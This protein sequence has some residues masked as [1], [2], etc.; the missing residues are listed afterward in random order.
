MW[1]E[2]LGSP[3]LRGRCEEIGE[4]REGGRHAGPEIRLQLI[5]AEAKALPRG[6]IPALRCPPARKSLSA[7]LEAEIGAGVGGGEMPPRTW[8][9]RD[10]GLCAHP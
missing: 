6:L 4:T 9:L 3:L 8:V 10:W 2:A 5:K 7:V 1:V